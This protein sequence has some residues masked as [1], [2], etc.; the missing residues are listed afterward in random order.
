MIRRNA[1]SLLRELATQYPVVGVVGPRQ[2]GKTTLCRSCFPSHAYA[3]LEA[4]DTLQFAT[5]DPRGFLES[6]R[7]G[8]VLDEV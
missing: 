5:D 3:S 6:I 7:E 4:P 1:A 8:A 2:A